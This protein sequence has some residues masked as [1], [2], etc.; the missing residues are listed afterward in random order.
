MASLSTSFSSVSRRLSPSEELGACVERV[1]RMVVEAESV[2][3]V[4]M[5]HETYQVSAAVKAVLEGRLGMA[6]CLVRRIAVDRAG[7]PSGSRYRNGDGHL[8]IN[9]RYG[10]I[11]RAAVRV[12]DLKRAERYH[13]LLPQPELRDFERERLLGLA[14]S[15]SSD[16]LD[17][18]PTLSS[19]P[20]TLVHKVIASGHMA[21]FILVSQRTPWKGEW[22]SIAVSTGN[23]PVTLWCL[24]NLPDPKMHYKYLVKALQRGHTK[25]INALLSFATEGSQSLD[26]PRKGRGSCCIEWPFLLLRIA[27]FLKS[28]SLIEFL[29]DNEHLTTALQTQSEAHDQEFRVLVRSLTASWDLSTLTRV[30]AIRSRT[31]LP[32][33]LTNDDRDEWIAS[34]LG[35]HIDAHTENHFMILRPWYNSTAATVATVTGA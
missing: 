24:T 16:L 9:E 22:L 33:F 18:L 35:Q 7:Q 21:L 12:G 15:G 29:L 26:G 3:F 2:A 1:A 27:V 14:R 4:S 23:L 11:V 25:T 28:M 8:V 20:P 10:K 6:D 13:H 17:L 19:L 5:I 31:P 34:L 32:S 30:L